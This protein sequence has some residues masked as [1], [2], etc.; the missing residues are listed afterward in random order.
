MEQQEQKQSIVQ[1]DK[2]WK[3]FILFRLFPP[4]V[5]TTLGCHIVTAANVLWLA[6]TISLEYS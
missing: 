6:V 2:H 3:I 4:T 5:I 1:K